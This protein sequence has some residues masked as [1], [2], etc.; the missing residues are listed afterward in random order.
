VTA[1]GK[2]GGWFY[3]VG[4]VLPGGVFGNVRGT[5]TVP[6]PT[7]QREVFVFVRDLVR[8]DVEDDDVVILSYYIAPNEIKG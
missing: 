8:K 3:T 4:Y 7:T 5:V 6:L 2:T 1:K